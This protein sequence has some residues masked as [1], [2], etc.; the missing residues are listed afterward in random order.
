[1]TDRPPR[2]A[3]RY[4]V[5]LVVRYAVAA[6]FVEQYVENLSIGGLFVVGAEHLPLREVV[7]IELDLPGAGRFPIR[8]EVCFQLSEAEAI[9]LGRKAGAG[10]AILESPAGLREALDSYLHRVSVRRDHL[11]LVSDPQAAAA[12]EAA[13]FHVGPVPTIDDLT[14][15]IA[16]AALAVIAV[17]V[18]SAQLA[19]YQA[20]ASAAGEPDLVVAF[21]PDGPFE[22][23]LVTIDS[24]L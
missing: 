15:V 16:R 22:A 12:L 18:P 2:A 10:M 17:V 23:L 5:R 7:E 11:V 21:E 9:G 4:P 19:A 3:P 1:M 20:V 8:A 6:E 13:G 14:A 24:R